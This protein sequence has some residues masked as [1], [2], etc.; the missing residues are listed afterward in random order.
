MLRKL[1]HI[2]TSTPKR[3]GIQSRDYMRRPPD[4]DDDHNSSSE[5]NAEEF[6]SRFLRK[7]PRFFLHIGIALGVLILITLIIV[8][9]SSTNP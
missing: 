2:H 9:S 3:M 7:H 8:K 5:S 6:F 1:S 4:E